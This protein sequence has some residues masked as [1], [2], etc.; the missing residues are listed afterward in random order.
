MEINHPIQSSNTG[1]TETWS[2]KSISNRFSFFFALVISNAYTNVSNDVWFFEIF[3]KF[4]KWKNKS[5]EVFQ[6]LKV[7]R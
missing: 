7:N 6:F 2:S 1:N 3:E 5:K 4:E